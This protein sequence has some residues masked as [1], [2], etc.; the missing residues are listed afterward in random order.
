MADDSDK[1]WFLSIVHFGQL[2]I[3]EAVRN[4]QNGSA[5]SNLELKNLDEEAEM[6][7]VLNT[8]SSGALLGFSLLVLLSRCNYSIL[9]ATDEFQ[10]SSR[11][12][13]GSENSISISTLEIQEL[14]QANYCRKY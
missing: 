3:S 2:D 12:T 9:E 5:V 8:A 1:N 4:F 13:N 11:H 10:D 14:V 7:Y 6:G